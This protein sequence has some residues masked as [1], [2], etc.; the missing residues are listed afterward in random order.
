[1]PVG[2]LV[3]GFRSGLA[4]RHCEAS[5]FDVQRSNGAFCDRK[6][7]LKWLF[8]PT[9]DPIC[10]GN[11][12]SVECRDRWCKSLPSTL[13]QVASAAYHLTPKGHCTRRMGNYRFRPQCNITAEEALLY[14]AFKHCHKTRNTSLKYSGSDAPVTQIL[15]SELETEHVEKGV[16]VAIS[17][18]QILIPATS[19]RENLQQGAARSDSD[20]GQ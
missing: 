1:M 7:P 9:P 2:R 5:S 8:P 3:Q 14:S 20:A 18:T 19:I 11:M 4:L 15:Y 12:S 6:A 17:P 13:S 10:H 16:N